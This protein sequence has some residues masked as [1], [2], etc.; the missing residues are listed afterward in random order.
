M[1]GERIAK[2]KERKSE[3]FAFKNSQSHKLL[4]GTGLHR[5]L[6]ILPELLTNQTKDETE[7]D[8]AESKPLWPS[9]V[10]LY[11]YV[12]P[13]SMPSVFPGRQENRLP[14]AIPHAPIQ[15]LCPANNLSRLYRREYEM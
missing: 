13:H 1:L 4:T 5:L 12:F 11:I 8:S 3:L 14:L 9:S 2:K 7:E 10:P 15:L 6:I